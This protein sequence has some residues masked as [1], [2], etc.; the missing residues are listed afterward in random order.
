MLRVIGKRG[1]YF[2]DGIIFPVNFSGPFEG[3]LSKMTVED[4]RAGT[5]VVVLGECHPGFFSVVMP[6]GRIGH[7][8]KDFTD[9]V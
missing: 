7:I 4:W 1:G 2:T 6:D 3:P 5:V 8:L 9:E